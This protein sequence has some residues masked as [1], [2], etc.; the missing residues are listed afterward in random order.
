MYKD[1]RRC[2]CGYETERRSSWYI[3]KKICKSVGGG[4]P[5]PNDGEKEQ[6]RERVS[7]LEQQLTA[8]D[9][10]LKEQLAAKDRQ[11]EE[12]IRCAKRPRCVTNNMT[13][14]TT[15]NQLINVFGKESLAHIT[16]AKL[17][18][19]IADPDTSVARLVTLKHSVEE[20]RNVRVPNVREKWVEVLTQDASTGERRWEVVPK[21]DILGNLVMDNALLLEGEADDNTRSGARFSQWR[22]RSLESQD[23]DGQLY[24]D[25]CTRVHQSLVQSTRV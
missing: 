22:E 23:Q 14:N 21:G 12:L 4:D 8:K 18:E 3:H 20:N 15:N 5:P 25:Q 7:S 11:I 13:N 6:L 10:Q 16:D 2:E 17:Q 9:E 19:L 1:A 24:K